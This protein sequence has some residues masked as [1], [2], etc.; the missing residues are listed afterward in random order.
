MKLA[1]VSDIHGFWKNINYPSADILIFAG[2]I[3]RNYSRNRLLDSNLQLTELQ[4]FNLFL[5]SL[6]QIYP[7]IIVVAGNHDFV[8]E[9]QLPEVKNILTN[10]HLLQNSSI[11]ING[12]KFYGSPHTPYFYNWAFNFPNPYGS[13]E[14]AHREAE[15]CWRAIDS[16][17]DVL[18][19]HGPPYNI[20][21]MAP[22]GEAVGDKH[23]AARLYKLPQLEL[24][25]F[26]HIHASYGQV[27]KL[28]KNRLIKFV[29]TAICDENY[30]PV[31]PVPIIDLP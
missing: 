1:T 16:N 3:L 15:L 18:I 19:T 14:R 31:H 11:V 26:G 12:R 7:N 22:D 8:F 4:E 10:A 25:I 9:Y 21:D 23:L 24:H 28:I 17:T 20:L 30:D 27:T 29:N 2:D 13:K 5:G 6:K